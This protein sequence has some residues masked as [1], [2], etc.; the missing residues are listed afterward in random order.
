M[1]IYGQHFLFTKTLSLYVVLQSSLYIKSF[2]CYWQSPPLTT[3]PSKTR[4]RKRSYCM[5]AVGIFPDIPIRFPF[6]DWIP[7]ARVDGQDDWFCFFFFE[8]VLFM[9]CNLYFCSSLACV[10]SPTPPTSVESMLCVT[11]FI[12]STRSWWKFIFS[13]LGHFK[14]RLQICLTFRWKHSW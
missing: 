14:S 12:C 2:H 7:H 1:T 9:V 6:P 10:T 13:F 8:V 11:S 5:S 4:T 3:I